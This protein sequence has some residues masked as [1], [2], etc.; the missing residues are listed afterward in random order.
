[1]AEAEKS[2]V[3][4]DY[5]AD[6]PLPA[7]QEAAIREQATHLGSGFSIVHVRP[8][9]GE[10]DRLRAALDA[11]LPNAWNVL[12]WEPEDDAPYDQREGWCQFCYVRV[13]AVDYFDNPEFDQK[14]GVPHEAD[15]R[16]VLAQP[17]LGS[18][19]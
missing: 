1:M 11:T 12:E 5:A 18:D 14:T 6:N 9:L 13:K 19:A 3:L 10:I 15:C 2:P 4:Y 16:W 8:L 7:S 17:L